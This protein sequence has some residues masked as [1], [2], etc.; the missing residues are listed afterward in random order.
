MRIK[1]GNTII[2]PFQSAAGMETP[3]EDLWQAG[4]RVT[5]HKFLWFYWLSFEK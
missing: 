1:I 5:F 2:V 4:W 3:T